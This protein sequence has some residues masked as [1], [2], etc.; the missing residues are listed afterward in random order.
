[1]K[2]I[3]KGE[4]LLKVAACVL[5]LSACGSE[6]SQVAA[7]GD[8]SGPW[9]AGIHYIPIDPTP[10]SESPR[11][12]LEVTEVFNYGCPACYVF[13][14][15]WVL[16]AKSQP[17]YVQPV[18]LPQVN[19]ANDRSYAR[20]YYTLIALNREDVHE[21]V[22]DTIHRQGNS[23]IGAT[24]AESL[25]LQI[26]FANAHGISAEVFRRAYQAASTLENAELAEKLTREYRVI[27]TPTIVVN[28]RLA[29]GV[30]RAGGSQFLLLVMQDLVRREL[31]KVSN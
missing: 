26:E 19:N 13:E 9:K 14:P 31:S 4:M 20:L 24:D 7:S 30:S 28:R 17:A 12:K 29:T 16:W 10:L 1:M 27:D 8:M 22:Y 23:L 2:K 6:T 25:Q 21:A 3:R 18:R 5:V 11:G 15:Q